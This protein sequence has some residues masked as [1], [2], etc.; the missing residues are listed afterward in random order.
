MKQKD[1]VVQVCWIENSA[2]RF[3]Q[4]RR[5]QTDQA[6]DASGSGCLPVIVN[7]TWAWAGW[8]A[9]TYEAPRHASRVNTLAQPQPLKHPLFPSS[10]AYLSLP[11]YLIILLLPLSGLRLPEIRVCHLQLFQILQSRIHIQ[12]HV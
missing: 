11:S 12:M 3:L 7:I 10:A 4:V 5:R 9:L 2:R 1:S 8:L 6:P